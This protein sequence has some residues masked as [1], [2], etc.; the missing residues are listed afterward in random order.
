MIF[1]SFGEQYGDRMNNFE[2]FNLNEDET[3]QLFFIFGFIIIVCSNFVLL[4]FLFKNVPLIVQRAWKESPEDEKKQRSFLSKIF[5]WILKFFKVVFSFLEEIEVLYYIAYGTLAIL[6]LVL[7]PFCFTFHLTEIMMRY[8]TLKN[9]LRSIYEPRQQLFITF[10]LLCVLEY[11][12]SITI[13]MLFSDNF[14][15]NCE[16]ML[17][18]FLIAFDQT[19]KVRFNTTIIICSFVLLLILFLHFFF[20]RFFLGKCRHGQPPH[21]QQPLQ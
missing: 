7:H 18:C 9:V 12:A 14:G 13:Y 2:F 3:R 20:F 4:F 21:G 6:G 5:N 10:V 11:M 8:P 19:F 15:G 16:S 1:F 17:Y